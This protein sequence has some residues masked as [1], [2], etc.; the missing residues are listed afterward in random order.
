MLPRCANQSLLADLLQAM[1]GPDMLIRPQFLATAIA[2]SCNF[3]LDALQESVM[4]K[5]SLELTIPTEAGRWKIADL[6]V[7]CQLQVASSPPSILYRLEVVKPTQQSDDWKAQM[8]S[9]AQLI[10]SMELSEESFLNV[11]YQQGEDGLHFRDAFLQQSQT[12]L[13]N[14]AVGFRSALKEIDAVAGISTK[15][16]KF[17]GF[18]PE[19]VM[20]A[21]DR[22]QEQPAVHAANPEQ[23]PTSILGGFLTSGLNRLAQTVSIPEEDA[24]YYKEWQTQQQQQQQHMARGH[25]STETR[26]Q[27][28]NRP[29][30]NP[31]SFPRGPQLYNQTKEQGPQ[32]YNDQQP[33]ALRH[34]NRTEAELTAPVDRGQPKAP[35]FGTV[36]AHVGQTSSPPLPQTN[37][38]FNERPQNFEVSRPRTQVSETNPSGNEDGWEMDDDDLFSPDELAAMETKSPWEEQQSNHRNE[39][40]GSSDQDDLLVGWVYDPETD[41]IPTRKRWINPRPGMRTKEFFM[42]GQ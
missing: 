11:S 15:L 21:A 36:A 29:Q 38:Y 34:Y 24:E 26:P 20:E 4:V 40:P 3:V 8:A 10:E 1:T 28:Y 2:T 19:D 32:L 16:S 14:S 7:F 41:I 9:A 17:Q 30:D 18:L 27:L 12:L 6:A 37:Q 39:A 35:P 22:V 25:G 23:R 13:Q 5:A 42:A 31:H 33:S